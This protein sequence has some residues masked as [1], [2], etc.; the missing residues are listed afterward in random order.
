MK[1]S[2][3]YNFLIISIIM[4][5]CWDGAVKGKGEPEKF[6]RT[7]TDFSKI[8]LESSADVYIIQG[9]EYTCTIET[10]PNIAELITTEV[11]NE[12][13]TISSKQ[14][15]NTKKLNIYITMPYVEKLSIKGSGDIQCKNE[16]SS[17]KLELQIEGSGNILMNKI[18]TRE[19][20]CSIG[21]SGDI[22]LITGTAKET[23]YVIDGSG[24][25]EA[26]HIDCEEL[27]AS[28]NGSGDI[29]CYASEN[30]KVDING[31][32]NLKYKGQPKVKVN[33]NGSGEVSSF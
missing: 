32:G 10:N 31:S 19:L 17:K 25:I 1:I 29:L 3:I 13:L 33:L 8:N 9:S 5:S 6:Q 20:I 12:E 22:K 24:S 27:E 23:T 14:N 7:I 28:I 18:V 26:D 2:Q 16:I 4:S 11:K 15:I 30:L 21:G